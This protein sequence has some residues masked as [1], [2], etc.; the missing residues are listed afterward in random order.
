MLLGL[1]GEILLQVPSDEMPASP[2]QPTLH[3]R[4]AL[5]TRIKHHRPFLFLPPPFQSQPIFSTFL[6]A[7]LP[8]IGLGRRAIN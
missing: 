3:T 1:E 8:Q 4:S 5:R 6:S 2:R 7:A